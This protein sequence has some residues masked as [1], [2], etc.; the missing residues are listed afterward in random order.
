MEKQ[1]HFFVSLILL[2]ISLS[3]CAQSEQKPITIGFETSLQSDVLREERPLLIYLPKD[4]DTSEKAYP[5]IYLLDGRG[6]FHHT[7][8]SV[9][10]LARNGRMP[11]CI[12][13][14]IPNTSDRT[15]DLTP[16]EKGPEFQFETAGGADD[17]LKFISEELMPF[18]NKAYRTTSYDLL[19]GH[20]FGGLFAIH[21]LINHPGTFDAY[22]AISPSLWWNDLELVDQAEAF[23]DQTPSYQAKLYMTL[24]SE[25]GEMLAGNQNLEKLLQEKAPEDF[26]W[27]FHRMEEETHGSVPHRSTYNGLETLFQDYQL[28]DAFAL[29]QKGGLDVIKAHFDRVRKMY[30]AEGKNLPQDVLNDLGYQLLNDGRIEEAIKVFQYNIDLY[31]G[32]SNAYDSLAEA[33]K[34]KG[35]EKKAIEYYQKSLDLFPGNV[36]AI[37]RLSEMGVEYEAKVFKVTEEELK[38]YVGKYET[39]GMGVLTILLEDGFLYGQPAGSTKEKLIPKAKHQF[40]LELFDI[41]V[42][43]HE[44]TEKK[45]E[46]ITVLSNGDQEVKGK[47]ME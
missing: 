23:F 25:D 12:V 11:E 32:S 1:L 3:L 26:F 41:K 19:I 45:I 22:L 33:F 29:Y 43:F 27:E 17:M 8:G 36:N 21:A 31:P 47:K 38:Q 7:T 5:V 15:R 14:A 16:P 18:I 28:K 39:Q 9:Q 13:V 10:F 6:H 34:D 35:D 44:G 20:S 4:Y 40:H 46:G 37:E 24:G 30:G 2:S 42:T